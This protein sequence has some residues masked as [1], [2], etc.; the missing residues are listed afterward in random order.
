MTSHYPKLI[1]VAAWY[2]GACFLVWWI[3]CLLGS[4]LLFPV[5]PGDD[6]FVRLIRWTGHVV[7]EKVIGLVLLSVAAFLA[8]RAHCPTWKWGIATGIAAGLV[9]E[10]IAA[11]LYII[12]FG[13]AAY[14]EYNDIFITI[15]ATLWLGFLFGHLCVWKQRL[16]EKQTVSLF[17]LS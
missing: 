3:F 8:S 11:L 5:K 12:R 16:R 14:V 9:Y 6:D 15:S 1:R 17:G 7:S 13:G 10:V 2:G 4:C